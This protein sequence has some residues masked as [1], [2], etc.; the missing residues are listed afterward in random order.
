MLKREYL[1]K[2]I[3]AVSASVLLILTIAVAASLLWNGTRLF[4]YFNHTIGE[5]IF[6]S[7]WNPSDTELGG[8]KVGASVFITG[9]V[10]VCLASVLM[11]APFSIAT[12]LYIS[13]TD[14]KNGEKYIKPMIGIFAGIPSVVYGWTALTVLVPFIRDIF[15]LPTGQSVLAASIVLAMM[16]FPTVTAVIADA[17][18]NV[19]LKY[20]EGAYGLG[21]TRWQM[22]YSILI[23]SA[24]SG[25]VTGFVLG[26]T[27]AFGEAL[28]VSMVIGKMRII[29][30]SILSP[31]VNLT[32]AIASDMG[33][34]T[35]GGELSYA[36]WSMALLLFCI[37]MFF[38]IIIHMLHRKDNK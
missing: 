11:V 4:T 20:I 3:S 35:A 16:I 14:K 7:A 18:K 9:S 31:A 25:I 32:T 21:V 8:G 38:V 10:A 29:P 37:S 12:A 5:F 13:V 17:F 15:N 24:S 2:Y 36:L 19:P 34:A 33:G 23:P 28:A 6:S 26:L 27:R 22:I 1:G 30:D